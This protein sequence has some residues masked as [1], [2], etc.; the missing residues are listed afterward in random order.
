MFVVAFRKCDKAI[1]ICSSP[2]QEVNFDSNNWNDIETVGF[3]IEGVNGDI[4]MLY[5]ENGVPIIR[6]DNVKYNFI[7]KELKCSCKLVNKEIWG[8]ECQFR[9][10]SFRFFYKPYTYDPYDDDGESDV[11]FGLWLIELL[12]NKD[13]MN[14]R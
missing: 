7:D 5:V 6:Y 13:N 8:V 12:H 9:N 14:I 2:F 11:N 3:Y 10:D 1:D 4:L